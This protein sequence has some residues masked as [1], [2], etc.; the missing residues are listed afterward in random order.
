[1]AFYTDT[2]QSRPTNRTASIRGA[3][4]NAVR[5]IVAS[6]NRSAE[7]QRMQALSDRELAD[8]GLSRDT[9]LRHVYRD[10]YYI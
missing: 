7:V 2:I 6:Q 4:S 1:M 5:R 3:L 10:L 8:M 9:I